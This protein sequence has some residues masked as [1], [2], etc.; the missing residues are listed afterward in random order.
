VAPFGDFFVCCKQSD[1]VCVF[2]D[3]IAV[4]YDVQALHLF[5]PPTLNRSTNSTLCLQRAVMSDSPISSSICR[6]LMDTSTATPRGLELTSL[7]PKIPIMEWDSSH[8]VLRLGIALYR[9][10][11]ID[12]ARCTFSADFRIHAT[13]LALPEEG[14]G[15]GQS[16]PNVP[17]WNFANA[18]EDVVTVDSE[19][20][21]RIHPQSKV[22]GVSS[23]LSPPSLASGSSGVL[24]RVWTCSIRYRGTFFRDHS[25]EQDAAFQQFPMDSHH[26]DVVVRVPR[27]NKQKIAAVEVDPTRNSCEAVLTRKDAGL[28]DFR[29]LDV[30]AWVFVNEPSADN[31][32]PDF[33]MS[34]C[35]A[36]RAK[37]YLV[38]V[39]MPLVVISLMSLVSFLMDALSDRVNLVLTAV[40][41]VVAFKFTVASRLPILSNATHLDRY[42]GSLYGLFV[43]M[44][45]SHVVRHILLLRG[46]IVST[47]D[48]SS[49]GAGEAWDIVS[50]DGIAGLAFSSVSLLIHAAAVVQLYLY[51]DRV[52]KAADTLMLRGQ[53]CHRSTPPLKERS[54]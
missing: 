14:D 19:P 54:R 37:Y 43:A 17:D 26:L 41:C 35:V 2:W 7:R 42:I 34:V 45:L 23:S 40:L 9:M 44:T 47:V 28:V 20:P 10:W 52:A 13:W 5:F 33:I 29:I 16:A 22:K 27:V 11:N 31:F 8:R 50:F 6:P 49:S 15:D 46:S 30:N 48:I 4:C 39:Y 1:D 25:S 24:S 21:R 32:K 38:C 18:V 36:R 51:E 3:V 53:E 12:D